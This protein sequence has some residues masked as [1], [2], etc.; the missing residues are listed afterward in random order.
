MHYSELV[1]VDRFMQQE[2]IAGGLKKEILDL[3]HRP[4]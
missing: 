1:Q 4:L 3:L 2:K